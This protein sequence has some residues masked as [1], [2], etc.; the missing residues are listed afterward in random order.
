MSGGGHNDRQAPSSSL[1]GTVLIGGLALVTMQSQGPLLH[2]PVI[3]IVPAIALMIFLM[4]LFK[5]S[6]QGLHFIADRIDLHA[7]Q[8]PYGL[9]G[10]AGLITKRSEIEDELC[11][12]AGP[13]FGMFQGEE[14]IVDIESNAV[15]VGPAGS[16]KTTGFV[17]VSTLTIQESCVIPDFKTE[18]A[19]VLKKP[20]EARGQSVRVINL[21]GLYEDRLGPS[22]TYNPLS[23]LV[24]NLW[25][26]GGLMDMSAELTEL[27]AQLHPIKDDDAGG[28]NARF[29]AGGTHDT[30]GAATAF[31][32]LTKEDKATLGDVA[33]LLNDPDELLKAMLY[34]SG[35]LLLEGDGPEEERMVGLPFE[36]MPWAHLHRD[37]IHRFAEHFR[38]IAAGLVKI[39]T[40]ADDRTFQSFL[41]GARQSLAPFNITTRAHRVMSSSSFRFSDLK[42]GT[43]AT[44]VFVCTD[45]TRT[46]SQ[47]PAIGMIFWA[48]RIALKRHQNKKR[49]V[50][51]LCDEASN[52]Y[53]SGLSTALTTDRTFGIRNILIFQSLTAFEETYSEET[54][55]VVLS[56]SEVKMLLPNQREPRVLQLAEEIAGTKS[57]MTKS[58]K[59]E[60][61]SD[62]GGIGNDFDF[63]E[64][65]MPVLTADQVRRLDQAVLVVGNKKPV[66]VDLP[67]IA[68]IHPFRS[69]IDINPFHGK[70]FLRPIA[71]RLKKRKGRHG[72]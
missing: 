1:P 29:F 62:T 13:Y 36:S 71:L 19:C 37:D 61:E 60:R 8:T 59:G 49:R 22:D 4:A 5:L 35:Q 58:F 20:L 12:E 11:D 26:P 39:M 7:A 25:R 18:L 17:M 6:A 70:P 50:Y 16:G 55:N 67:P 14:L 33:Q 54:L 31:V 63:R 41:T 47:K 46:E 42:E 38:G 48:A 2:G 43:S 9:Y 44:T 10:D 3:S 57:I 56:E 45:P 72:K 53:M 23:V 34:M 32:L 69:Q 40:Q 24:D 27:S 30:I 15:V 64:E 65:K 21:G 28:S 66:L 52:F 68:A 51:F